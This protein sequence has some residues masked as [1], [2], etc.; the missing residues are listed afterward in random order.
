MPRLK[1]AAR[2]E[3]EAK[4]TRLV[5]DPFEPGAVIRVETRGLDPLHRMLARKEIDTAQAKA[6]SML[7]DAHELVNATG[8]RAVDFMREKVDGGRRGN[9]LSD[10]V[11]LAAR[12][13]RQAEALL[14]WQAYRLVVCIVCNGCPGTVIAEQSAVG[15][16]RRVVQWQ[17]RSGLEQLAI[18]WGFA[19]D[20]R[21]VRQ[22]AAITAAM[23]ER[24]SW[25]HEVAEVNIVYA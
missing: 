15:V 18:L 7:R 22:R 4:A 21:R 25:G 3:C 14:G 17:L 9:G 2:T 5:E 12:R 23:T 19:Q 10:S 11:L 13:L 16:D 6:G 8:M 20:P 24:A 1:S